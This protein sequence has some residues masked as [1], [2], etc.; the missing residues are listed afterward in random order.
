MT[1]QYSQVHW[2]QFSVKVLNSLYNTSPISMHCNQSYARSFPVS[3]SLMPPGPS[4]TSLYHL[5]PPHRETGRS[6]LSQWSPPP[7][8][9]HR[10]PVRLLGLPLGQHPLSEGTQ[11]SVCLSVMETN[12]D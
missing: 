5:H 12:P 2:D 3:P 6:S 8:K 11:V 1:E 9:D 4:Q 7:S 10:T